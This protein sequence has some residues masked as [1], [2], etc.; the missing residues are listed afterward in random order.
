MSNLS[1][2]ATLGTEESGRGG[3][4]VVMGYDKFFSE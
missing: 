2:R 1:T 4:V 3:E